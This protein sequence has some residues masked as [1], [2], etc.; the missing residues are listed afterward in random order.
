ME[1]YF[2]N[3]A[4]TCVT[5]DVSRAVVKMMTEDFGNPSSKHH[6]GVEAE[7]YLRQAREIGRAHV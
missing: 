4:T 2:D 6:K 7:H 3:S 5:E 1:A